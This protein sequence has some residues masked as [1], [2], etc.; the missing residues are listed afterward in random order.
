MCNADVSIFVRQARK[1]CVVLVVYVDDILLT[2][3]DSAGIEKSRTFLKKHF[4]TK[5]LGRL[6]YFLGIEIDHVRDKIALS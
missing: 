1:S 5:D 3:S 6:Q 4:D 2:E